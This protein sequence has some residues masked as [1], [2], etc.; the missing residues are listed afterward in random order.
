MRANSVTRMKMPG[1]GLMNKWGRCIT[2]GTRMIGG[3]RC[4]RRRRSR[5]SVIKQY[6]FINIEH[7]SNEHSMSRR[8]LVS[9]FNAFQDTIRLP[10]TVT[11]PLNRFGMVN[12]AGKYFQTVRI[13]SQKQNTNKHN[14]ANRRKGTSATTKRD[15]RPHNTQ[16]HDI[17]SSENN[18]PWCSPWL[19]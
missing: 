7:M 19:L 5:I 2:C 16:H 17:V 6:S 9:R 12:S 3:Y 18:N 14:I 13:G 11:H 4:P 15:N 1:I 8:S 10:V